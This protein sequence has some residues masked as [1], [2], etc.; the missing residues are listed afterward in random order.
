M[1]TQK[2]QKKSGM[3]VE[4]LKERSSKALE[5]ARKAILAEKTQ[6]GKVLEALEYYTLH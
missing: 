1:G 6:C 2:S 3:L 5:L 4:E